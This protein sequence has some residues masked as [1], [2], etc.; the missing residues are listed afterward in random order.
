MLVHHAGKN[1]DFRGSSKLAATFETIIKLERFAEQ[2]ERDGFRVQQLDDAKH[3]CAHFRVRWDKV[4]AGG[5]KRK[6]REVAAILLNDPFEER[7]DGLQEPRKARWEYLTLDLPRLDDLKEHLQAG[8]LIT[9]K[10]IADLYGVTPTMARKY[11]DKGIQVGLWTEQHISRWFAKGKSLRTLGKT[12]PPGRA[13][14][15]WKH[16]PLEIGPDEEIPF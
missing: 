11:I 2:S 6:V 14:L 15:D 3:G 13:S 4:R 8:E 9:Q 5:P 1:G 12:Q 16:E 10:E 7:P